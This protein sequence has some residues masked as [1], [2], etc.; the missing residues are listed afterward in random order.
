MNK[1]I[2][3]LAPVTVL[4]I[5][6]GVFFLL[7]WAKPEPEKKEEKPRPLSVFVEPVLQST[8]ALN[9][10]TSG[11]VRARTEMV[12]VAQIAGRV[13]S[14]SQEFT[15]GGL[16]LP[17]VTLITIE[18][19]DYRFSL[20]QAEAAV[21]TMEVGLQTALATANVARKQLQNANNASDLA[22]KKPQVAQAAASL[23]AAEADLAQAQVNL[24]RT[25]L[26]LPFEGRIIDTS[27]DIGQYITPGTRLGRAFATDVVEIRLA[28][29]DSHLAS[30]DLPIGFIAAQGEGLPVDISALVAG[31]NQ[32]WHGSLTRLDAS[33]ERETRM[34]Y[35]IVE[36]HSPYDNNTSNHGMPLAV[37]L[38][39]KAKIRGR[40]IH[41]AYVIPRDAL[42]AGNQVF[43]VNDQ[44]RLEV[45]TV[46]VTHSTASEAIIASGLLPD[47]RVIISSIRNPI[48][49]MA[50]EALQQNYKETAISNFPAKD[51]IGG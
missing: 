36:V 41:N 48:Q 4:L 43:V 46:E 11:E 19:T 29:S 47:E 13:V 42:R 35:G 49:G 2:S 27:V 31:K 37:G 14:V 44:G 3:I 40:E 23:K 10:K 34:L 38:Y 20:H 6:G 15:E 21:A 39:V 32:L 50:L 45:R 12:I 51:S 33:I 1:L 5:G 7:D 17:N 28:L 25:N 26:S 24:A 8:I 18:D 16:V 22:L 9:V 30:L